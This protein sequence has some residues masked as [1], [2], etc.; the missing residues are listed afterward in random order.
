MA[1]EVK[2]PVTAEPAE[3]PKTPSEK[4]LETVEG[5]LF[6]DIVTRACVLDVILRKKILTK[7]QLA[8][9]VKLRPA[10]E[11]AERVALPVA[12]GTCVLALDDL[13]EDPGALGK[14]PIQ[15]ELETD[16]SDAAVMFLEKQEKKK[17]V[18]SEKLGPL[19]YPLF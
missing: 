10:I 19:S 13:D 15:D 5:D 16:A 12:I 6:S 1:E 2:A 3:G 7:G 11:R 9:I 18:R 17:L 8:K 14:T 4:F